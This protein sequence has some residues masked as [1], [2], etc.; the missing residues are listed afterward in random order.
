MGHEPER[1]KHLSVEVNRR[2]KPIPIAANVEYH[3]GSTTRDRDRIGVRI[4][5]SQL[6]QIP[7][8]GKPRVLEPRGE[9]L[10]S[11]RVLCRPGFHS[12]AVDDSHYYILQYILQNVKYPL[13]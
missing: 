9:G 13:N 12:A 7:P 3:D 10:C 1:V 4:D 6:G 5:A 8:G 2:D 11:V